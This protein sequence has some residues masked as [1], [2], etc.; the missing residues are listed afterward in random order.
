M[1]FANKF[2]FDAEYFKTAQGELAVP[3][4][5]LGA[6]V[7]S[8]APFSIK[9][10]WANLLKVSLLIKNIWYAN[11][12]LFGLALSIAKPCDIKQEFGH[13]TGLF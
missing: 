3:E 4:Q 12:S 11:I 1:S 7:P 9:N 5:W 10:K 2:N 8:N 6:T 13:G